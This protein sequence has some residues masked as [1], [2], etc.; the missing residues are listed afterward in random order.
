MAAGRWRRTQKGNSRP[1]GRE[2]PGFMHLAKRDTRV[3]RRLE[4]RD[5]YL[6]R[7]LA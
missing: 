2:P 3:R 5:F 6:L 7:P 4:A 1:A